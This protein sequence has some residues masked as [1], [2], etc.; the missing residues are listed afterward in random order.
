MKTGTI[1]FEDYKG[2]TATVK[3][4]KASSLS[5]VTELAET[6]GGYTRAKVVSASF[7]ETTYFDNLGQ[8][9]FGDMLSGSSTEHYDRVS[10]KA[11][12]LFLDAD[13]GS[14]HSLSIPAPNDNV[15]DA[16]QEVSSSVAEDLLDA[17]ASANSMESNDLMY[18]GGFLVGKKPRM[19]ART[20]SGV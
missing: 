15:F 1:T 18:K 20:L 11:K 10:Q 4:A 7:T 19:V 6:L 9:D 12:L 14:H 13:T 5:A 8:A 2:Q 3:V 16:H 17:Y